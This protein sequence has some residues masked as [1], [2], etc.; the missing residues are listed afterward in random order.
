MTSLITLQ[1]FTNFLLGKGEA[2]L[3]LGRSDTFE[4]DGLNKKVDS[5]QQRVHPLRIRR[6]YMLR[7]GNLLTVGVPRT[8]P[9]HPVH[10]Q[11]AL[12]HTSTSDD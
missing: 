7:Q 11:C 2:M 4:Q 1:Y 5:L 12:R 6:P 10:N 3:R 9:S 8:T